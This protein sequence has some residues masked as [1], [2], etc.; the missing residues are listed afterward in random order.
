MPSRR[1]ALAELT[2]VGETPFTQRT[3]DVVSLGEPCDSH[4]PEGDRS[5]R[6][7]RDADVHHVCMVQKPDCQQDKSD[8]DADDDWNPKLA[9]R[10]DFFHG[11]SRVD[12]D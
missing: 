7:E 8:D 10:N 5:G 6:A 11:M 9:V 4:Q 12:V 3:T 2:R 1:G